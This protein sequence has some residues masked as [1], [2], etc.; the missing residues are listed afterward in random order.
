MEDVF[1]RLCRIATNMESAQKA[2][3]LET[4]ERKAKE[5]A[6]A[7]EEAAAI[8]AKAARRG[9]GRNQV[10]YSAL[11]VKTVKNCWKPL[12]TVKNCWKPL[13]TVVNR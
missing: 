12:K 6:E 5:E 9:A 4:A 10:R 8:E 2:I 3:Q 7:R 1:V 13:K 11:S